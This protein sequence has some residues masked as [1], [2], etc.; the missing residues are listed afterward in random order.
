MEAMENDGNLPDGFSRSKINI[1]FQGE[2][3]NSALGFMIR[4]AARIDIF[5]MKFLLEFSLSLFVFPKLS[6]IKLKFS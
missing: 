1:K 5:F 3:E 2:K 6:F 4:P